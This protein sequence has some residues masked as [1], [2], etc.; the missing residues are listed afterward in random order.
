MHQCCR[1]S[2]ILILYAVGTPVSPL[3]TS[4]G[5]SHSKLVQKSLD[6]LDNINTILRGRL[7]G[8]GRPLQAQL[9]PPAVIHRGEKA[10]CRVLSKVLMNEPQ[11]E[12]LLSCLE[13][14]DTRFGSPEG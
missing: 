6:N 7:Q 2:P 5:S 14:R 9:Q 11:K 8:I 3:P 13:I 4:L 10:V 1:R 12:I